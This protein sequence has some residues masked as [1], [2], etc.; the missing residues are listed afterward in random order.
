M[1]TV[2]SVTDCESHRSCEPCTNVS[3]A[4]ACFWSISNQSCNAASA[5]STENLLIKNSSSCPKFLVND[6]GPEE[7]PITVTVSNDE[8]G[9]VWLLQ[10][11]T[12]ECLLNKKVY[13]ASVNNSR[14]VCT[15]Q[16]RDEHKTGTPVESRSTR[17]LSVIFNNTTLRFDKPQDHYVTIYPPGSARGCRNVS[18]TKCLWDNG[19]NQ[20]FYCTWCLANERCAGNATYH[21]C[22]VRK[23]S[24]FSK[25]AL[26]QRQ[27]NVQLSGR[28]PFA[29]IERFK[30]TRG[31][32]NGGT[33]IKI[34]ILNHETLYELRPPMTVRVAGRECTSV[35]AILD[36]VGA[37]TLR[38]VVD[39]PNENKTNKYANEGPV[40]VTYYMADVS[41]SSLNLILKSDRNFSFVDPAITAVW[42]TN[43]P[44]TG[45]T[46]LTIRGSSFDFEG[47]QVHAYV[48][49]HVECAITKIEPDLVQC[50][51]GSVNTTCASGPVEIVFNGT[52][53][54]QTVRGQRLSFEYVA[55]MAMNAG[56]T[57]S[58]I[59]S[60]GTA[61]WVQGQNFSS[62]K[63]VTLYVKDDYASKSRV[64]PCSIRNDTHIRC[65]SP[66]FNVSTSVRNMAFGFK[67]DFNSSKPV[68]RAA[69]GSFCLYPDPIVSDFEV[70]G[71]CEIT[72]NG[73][74][75]DR[76]YSAEDVTV[77]LAENASECAVAS[78]DSNQIVCT[79]LPSL[80]SDIHN[81]TVTVL[82]GGFSK[83]V[84]R[85]KSL[86]PFSNPV[87]T[88]VLPSVTIATY[89]LFIAFLC[90]AL[91]FLK[92]PKT[93]DLSIAHPRPVPT[94]SHSLRR[95]RK[96]D[97]DI[98]NLEK[99]NET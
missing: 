61:L 35:Q 55:V 78:V 7:F 82:I 32:R 75:L 14:I 4:A 24:S 3:L 6:T 49:D 59:S 50:L 87:T 70:N 27:K 81:Q 2:S 21:Y 9:L 45:G 16:T 91:F 83:N 20:R 47:T 73:V 93:Y 23:Y 51:T 64:S 58:G 46:L 44:V 84:T 56:Q 71:C 69:S 28:C 25:I 77:R 94:E 36:S 62:M 29:R 22:D 89:V 86:Y 52:S 53:G 74:N 5:N 99:R 95:Q 11:S 30:P 31:L 60:G 98:A 37:N 76:G 80:P 90:V 12:V 39:E 43:G 42:P 19:R 88:I 63:N 17:Y 57:F 1:E 26:E 66:P 92:A 18:C 34:E 10:N 54:Q 48:A 85:K 13:I 33:T 97:D 79:V 96:A 72:I 41:N 67:V 15:D 38:C 8:T 65:L 68:N 40:E